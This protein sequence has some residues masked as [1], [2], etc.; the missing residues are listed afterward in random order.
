MRMSLRRDVERPIGS[1][2]V[3][4]AKGEAAI[5]PCILEYR[6]GDGLID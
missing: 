6:C 3:V 1:L 4:G 5:W 2:V